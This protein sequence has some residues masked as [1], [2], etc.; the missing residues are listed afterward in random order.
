MKYPAT[1]RQAKAA[2][3]VSAY[4]NAR[5]APIDFMSA[6]GSLKLVADPAHGADEWLARRSFQLGSQ[7]A[8]VY[9]EEVGVKIARRIP[10]SLAD[11]VAWQNAA[12]ILHEDFQQGILAA[13]QLQRALVQI[14]RA[15]EY[16]QL[17][18]AMFENR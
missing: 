6:R 12:G 18:T 14:H 5:R 11:Q 16:V 17:Q 13:G 4:H 9:V 15:V 1:E 2:V 3:A 8:H 10:D 7:P